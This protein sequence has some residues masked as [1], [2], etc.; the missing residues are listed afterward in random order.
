M[1]YQAGLNEA[2]RARPALIIEAEDYERLRHVALQARALQPA[3]AERLLEEIER[4]DLR[5]SDEV[6]LDVVAIGSDVTFF[7]DDSEQAETV[8]LVLPWEADL[9]PGWVSILTPL[10][11]A[12]LGL[13][14][15]QS[16]HW[17]VD[18]QTRR[19]TVIGVNQDFAA[20]AADRARSRRTRASPAP[21]A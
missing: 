8:R 19:L 17:E 12:L 5:P 10:G 7:E 2:P 15:G 21:R 20:D 18:G 14:V 1:T 13:S 6:P 4:A 9:E 11:A 16:I 3:L